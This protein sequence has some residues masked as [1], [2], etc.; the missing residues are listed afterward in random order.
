MATPQLPTIVDTNA[1]SPPLVVRQTECRKMRRTGRPSL[2][3][4]CTAD[5]IAGKRY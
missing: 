5:S 4:S 2:W 1:A 3:S